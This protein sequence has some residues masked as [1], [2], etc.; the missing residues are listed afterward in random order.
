[1]YRH[2]PDKITPLPLDNVHK[3]DPHLDPRQKKI[4]LVTRLRMFQF[5]SLHIRGI[6]LETRPLHQHLNEPVGTYWNFLHKI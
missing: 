6:S 5:P 4:H 1:M 3:L 2:Q